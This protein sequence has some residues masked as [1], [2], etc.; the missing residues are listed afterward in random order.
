MCW[1]YGWDLPRGLNAA[2]PQQRGAGT[3]RPAVLEGYP[4][5]GAGGRVA[6]GVRTSSELGGV[7]VLLRK[8]LP[9]WG[10]RGRRRSGRWRVTRRSVLEG[11]TGGV[12][13][14]GAP[15][16]PPATHSIGAP[17]PLHPLGHGLLYAN[18]HPKQTS[19]VKLRWDLSVLLGG[20]KTKPKQ[21][22]KQPTKN[23]K[24]REIKIYILCKIILIIP[25]LLL[26]IIPPL[27]GSAYQLLGLGLFQEKTG[28]KRLGK[29]LWG[30]VSLTYHEHAS[31]TVT[32]ISWKRAC[33]YTASLW[34]I[35]PG[36]P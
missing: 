24:K 33:Y 17:E 1:H 6:E 19:S 27:K 29:L 4:A 12:R 26:L 36:K 7:W 21:K 32:A 8:W 22:T 31:C 20:K 14:A 2:L 28:L 10:H 34:V 15:L 30:I 5:P 11:S 16:A 9:G 3:Q 35:V 13:P 23:R 18:Y 25:G